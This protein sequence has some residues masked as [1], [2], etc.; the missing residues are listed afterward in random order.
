MKRALKILKRAQEL[1]SGV[2][3]SQWITGKYTDG[4][5]ACC[6]LGHYSRL[7]SR[8]KNDFSVDNCDPILLGLHEAMFKVTGKNTIHINDR[9]YRGRKGPKGR[10]M[11]AIKDAIAKAERQIQA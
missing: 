4:E 11:L 8:R 3:T 2:P 10:V 7:T 5:G 1:L 9:S 6:A